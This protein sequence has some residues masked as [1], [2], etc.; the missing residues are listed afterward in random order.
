MWVGGDDDLRPR[1]TMAASQVVVLVLLLLLP[2]PLLLI[3]LCTSSTTNANTSATCWCTSGF[4]SFGT[5]LTSGKRSNLGLKSGDLKT[6][7]YGIRA[8]GA[9][10][11]RN[12][13]LC[14]SFSP[15]PNISDG[16][17]NLDHHFF[18][19][20]IFQIHEKGAS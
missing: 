11:L 10:T 5:I 8:M 4:T 12:L 9:M 2:L 16:N 15:H 19:T 7:H 6:M 3:Q 20:Q 1:R 17:F 14:P 13:E 18:R